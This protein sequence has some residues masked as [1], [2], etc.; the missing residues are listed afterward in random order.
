MHVKDV[1]ENRNPNRTVLDVS[2]FEFFLYGKDFSVPR[3]NDES[4]PLRNLSRRIPEKPGYEQRQD[5]RR[6]GNWDPAQPC[7][8]Q[9]N[10]SGE[11]NE[12]KSFFG[13]GNTSRTVRHLVTISAG[14]QQDPADA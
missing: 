2:R 6:H 14:N 8:N 13:K 11:A 10:A 5:G 9:C 1:E 3:R 12:G 7:C 4:G